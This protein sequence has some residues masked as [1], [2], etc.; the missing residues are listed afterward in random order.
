VESGTFVL[1]FFLSKKK[2]L[3]KNIRFIIFITTR[4]PVV[5]GLKK[6]LL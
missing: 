6:G 1:D 3:K 5:S 2:L 4:R